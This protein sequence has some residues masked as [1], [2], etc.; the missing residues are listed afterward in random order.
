MARP[1]GVSDS[2]KLINSEGHDWRHMGQYRHA[3]M[4]SKL[5]CVRAVIIIFIFYFYYTPNPNFP[6]FMIPFGSRDCFK[7]FNN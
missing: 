5:F 2:L 4:V 1:L 3:L 7:F 6:G